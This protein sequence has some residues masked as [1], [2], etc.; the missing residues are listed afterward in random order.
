MRRERTEKRVEMPYGI[1]PDGGIVLERRKDGVYLDS[2]I[3]NTFRKLEP[4]EESRVNFPKK[5]EGY[6][7]YGD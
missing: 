6:G 5:S 3:G 7:I 2:N 4:V 1:F